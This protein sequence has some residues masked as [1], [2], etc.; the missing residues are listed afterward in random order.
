MRAWLQHH[1][2]ALNIYALLCRIGMPCAWARRVAR[3]WEAR[4]TTTL[5]PASEVRHGR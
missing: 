5:Y 4:V 3:W 1:L 2:N